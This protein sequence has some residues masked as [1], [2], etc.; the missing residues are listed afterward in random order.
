MPTNLHIDDRLLAEAQRLGEFRTKRETV[1]AAL[2]AFVAQQK[3]L[4]ILDLMGTVDY[5]PDYDYKKLRRLRP[6]R[7]Q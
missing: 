7:Q 6:K 3:R 1:T 5:R 4:K 2:K